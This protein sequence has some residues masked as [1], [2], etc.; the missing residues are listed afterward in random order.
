[1]IAPTFSTGA[2]TALRID[3]PQSGT[4][5]AGRVVLILACLLVLLFNGFCI[6]VFA[7]DIRGAYTN[8]LYLEHLLGSTKF[9]WHYESIGRY[10]ASGVM[11]VVWFLAG[12][13]LCLRFLIW[14]KAL[15]PWGV[16]AALTLAFLG[17]VRVFSN[18]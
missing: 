6:L 3:K 15:I 12:A 10:I 1:M 2:V 4:A 8:P 5:K 9:G 16:H 7:E 13:G 11:L 17:Y 14:K 18:W